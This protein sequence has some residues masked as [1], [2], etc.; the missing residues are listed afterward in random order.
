MLLSVVLSVG[1]IGQDSA[2]AQDR[3][4]SLESLLNDA[5]VFGKAVDRTALPQTNVT[6]VNRKVQ[7]RLFKRI[8]SDGKPGTDELAVLEAD[9]RS[10]GHVNQPVVAL[11]VAQ[12]AAQQSTPETGH[13]MFRA[14]KNL[15][16]DLPY[17][18]FAHS[19]YAFEHDLGAFHVW[20][21]AFVEGWR[22]AVAWPDT[23]INWVLKFFVYTL[24][25]FLLAALAFILGQTIRQTPIVAY[26]AAR[27]MP[28][29]FSSNQTVVIVLGCIVVPGL[30]MQS[31]LA[32]ILI[33]IAFLSLTQT[34][35]ERAITF[36]LFAALA[37][38]P[39]AENAIDTLASYVGSTSQSLVHAQ[40]LHCDAACA[41]ELDALQE[42]D[43]E[44]RFIT[45]TRLV[46]AY[47]SGE[48]AL[49]G[50]VVEESES[51]EWPAS[52]RGYA[53][54]LQGASLV[55]LG[56]P[57][58]ALEPLGRAR[59]LL[60]D[61]AAPSLNL[62]RA[63]HMRD[64]LDDASSALKEASRR[65]IH[66]VSRFLR[67]DRRD[68]NSFLAIALLPPTLLVDHHLSQSADPSGIIE[69]NWTVLAGEHLAYDWAP[70][71]GGAGMLVVVLGYFLRRRVAT[72]TP[73][74]RC[75]MARDPRDEPETGGH[76]LCLP[77]Y[78]TFVTGAGLDYRA[79]A[80]NE[81]VLGRRE[82]AQEAMRRMLSVVVPGSGHHLA[83]R[84]VLGFAVTFSLAFGSAL[85][86]MPLGP[87]RPMHELGSNNWGGAQTLGWLLVAVAILTAFYAAARDIYPLEARDSR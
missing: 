87:I 11:A 34:L 48:P 24:I 60:V 44:N 81:S 85:V 62:M 65:D 53:L 50:R 69:S 71:L 29:G 59:A 32:S 19:A 12:F 82:R 36:L 56:K 23:V 83:G 84:S 80:Y 54:N 45:F 28:R 22:R 57:D 40:Y 55:A 6:D 35:R 46:V 21:V 52:L 4:S 68:A 38:V 33:L 10:L 74:P 8:A 25:A 76:V 63:Y 31:P 39:M 20:A 79:R 77:C 43:P 9:A 1:A 78:R 16:P 18:Y 58:D 49:L 2:I 17:V 42:F 26:D 66:E 13:A 30:L 64:E 86:L 67:S 41:E 47:R 70:P 3:D 7:W 37:L 5:D 14:A 51:L 61:Q 15:A 75:G 73:C 27:S 72:S